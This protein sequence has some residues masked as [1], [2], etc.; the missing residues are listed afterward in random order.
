MTQAY[1][2]YSKYITADNVIFHPEKKDKIPIFK[3][4]LLFEDCLINF[5]D[6]F[7]DFVNNKEL[8]DFLDNY[9]IEYQ[10]GNSYDIFKEADF[11][12]EINSSNKQLLKVFNFIHWI[13]QMFIM[14]CR[15]NFE[16]ILGL[17]MELNICEVIKEFLK[18]KSYLINSAMKLDKD[19]ENINII[20]N[21]L[22]DIRNSLHPNSSTDLEA[23]KNKKYQCD[24]N[25]LILPNNTKF[26]LFN[27]FYK[28][29]YVLYLERLKTIKFK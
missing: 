2:F 6:L 13:K 11:T 10:K 16:Y 9:I 7:Q 28:C 24:T 20:V 29:I 19:F 14:Y 17:S 21:F 8:C 12:I 26:T 23:N 4:N 22:N 27:L 25:E 15:F 1:N 3:A 5:K 18:R